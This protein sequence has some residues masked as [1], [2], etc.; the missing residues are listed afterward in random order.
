VLGLEEGRTYGP[1]GHKASIA[2][3]PW[4][5]Q[6]IATALVLD[7]NGEVE[8]RNVIGGVALPEGWSEVAAI[9]AEG[10]ELVLIDRSGSALRAP[11]DGAFLQ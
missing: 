10:D 5:R 1:Y 6:G 7:P 11:F 9:D 8:V 3:N 2:E 4:T